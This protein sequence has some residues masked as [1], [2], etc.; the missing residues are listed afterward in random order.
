MTSRDVY[1]AA[2]GFRQSSEFNFWHEDGAFATA[3]IEAGY[4]TAILADL[5]VHHASGPAYSQDAKVADEKARYYQIRDRKQKRK[6]RIKGLL[7]A[8]PPI[9]ALNR[10]Y[11]WYTYMPERLKP[12]HDKDVDYWRGK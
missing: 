11:H 6:E 7:E 1:D 4:R 2:G 5:K 8:V 12:T 9:R 10:R 3:V